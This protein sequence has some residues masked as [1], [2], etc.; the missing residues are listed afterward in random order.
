MYIVAPVFVSAKMHHNTY[1]VWFHAIPTET[2][3]YVWD[4]PDNELQQPLTALLA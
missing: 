4:T 3:Y 2:S 1:V